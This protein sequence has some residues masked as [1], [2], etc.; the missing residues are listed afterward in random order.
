M[1][2]SSFWLDPDAYELPDGP[3]RVLDITTPAG[4]QIPTKFA[5]LSTR[6]LRAVAVHPWRTRRTRNDQMLRQK[7]KSTYV[8]QLHRM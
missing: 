6:G 8:N 3:V 4:Y 7:R 2:N 5:V 1:L